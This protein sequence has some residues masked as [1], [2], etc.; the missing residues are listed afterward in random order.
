MFLR[1]SGTARFR[2]REVRGALPRGRELWESLRL[3]QKQGAL[4]GRR[5]A[6]SIPRQT[7]NQKI[8]QVNFVSGCMNVD[9]D[10]S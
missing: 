3:P 6:N 9:F 5:P 4:G 2:A 10:Q 8:T 7:Q 1:R